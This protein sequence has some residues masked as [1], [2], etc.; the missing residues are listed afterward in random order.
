MN[1][2]FTAQV[3]YYYVLAYFGVL[4][5][6]NHSKLLY[7][8]HKLTRL[9]CAFLTRDFYEYTCEGFNFIRISLILLHKS[10]DRALTSLVLRRY[11]YIT[12]VN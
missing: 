8:L 7:W 10:V 1:L 5:P 9:L 11:F 6:V 12:I 3:S 2:L 4:N